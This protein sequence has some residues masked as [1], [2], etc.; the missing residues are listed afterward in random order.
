MHRWIP[1]V[2]VYGSVAI[3]DDASERVSGFVAP[4]T[5]ELTGRVTDGEGAPRA[6]A[7]ITIVTRSGE[8]TITTDKDGWYRADVR[9]PATLVF[10]HGDVRITGSAVTSTVI[11]QHEAIVVRD[12]LPPARLARVLSDPT[13]IP[14]YS[15]EI[16]DRD[17]WT[18]A[19]LLVEVSDT[20]VVSRVKLLNRPGFDLDAIA[21]R[22][23]FKLKFEPARDRSDKPI[24]SQMIWTFE[25][26]S[27]WWMKNHRYDRRRVPREAL[28]VPCRGSGP[29]HGV[30]RDCSRPNLPAVIT[31][32]WINRPK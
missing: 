19:W 24:R 30:Y 13:I 29:T 9:E 16:V 17:A 12:A 10:V 23:A 2:L 22:D 3:A 8:R 7:T 26:P 1:L 14:E 15:D 4:S 28:R 5:G 25:W 18:R 20:G 32:A 31:A 21:V 27:F 6:N 11:D